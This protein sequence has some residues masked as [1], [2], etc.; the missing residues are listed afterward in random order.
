MAKVRALQAIVGAYPCS[1][2]DADYIKPTLVENSEGHLVTV[3]KG[4]KKFTLHPAF[5]RIATPLDIEDD[6]VRQ[7]QG[8]PSRLTGDGRHVHV[9]ANPDSMELPDEYAQELARRGLVEIVSR[10]G[11]KPKGQQNGGKLQEPASTY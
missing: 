3:R 7:S 4:F 9:P 6:K 10:V 1:S 5:D 11:I 2:S 8:M